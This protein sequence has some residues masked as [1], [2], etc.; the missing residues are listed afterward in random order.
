MI[1]CTH[2]H[3]IVVFLISPLYVMLFIIYL[4]IFGF[5]VV[6]FLFPF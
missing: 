5:F 4:F 1:I 6:V 2:G 3:H